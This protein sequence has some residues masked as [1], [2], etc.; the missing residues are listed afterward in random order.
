MHPRQPNL[1]VVADAFLGL[2][3]I[4][5]DTGASRVLI[6]RTDPIGVTLFNDLDISADGATVF[7]SD[8]STRFPLPL[9]LLDMMEMRG[10]GRL[11]QYD[12]GSGKSKVLMSGL[13]FANGVQLHPDGVSVL[14]VETWMLRI[15]R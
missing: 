10:T 11:L 15:Q 9:L 14:V 4:D 5:T 3:T 8:S 7:V 13:G 2:H 6:G 12:A 1:L